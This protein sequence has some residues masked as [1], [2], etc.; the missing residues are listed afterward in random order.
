MR[1]MNCGLPISPARTLTNCP[2]CGAP[3]NSVQGVQQQQFEQGGWGN[4]NT[5]GGGAPQNNPWVQVGSTTPQR[6][7]FQQ[8]IQN[9]VGIA[10]GRTSGAG[11]NGSARPGF[12]ESPLTPR[13]SPYTPPTKQK[14]SRNL[15][16]VAGLCVIVGAILLVL[17]VVLGS[18][19]SAHSP[20]T[21][22]TGQT[23][24]T[25]VS[26]TQAVV[27]PTT[28][29][30]DASPTAS[31]SPSPTGTAYPDAQYISDA[32]MTTGVDSKTMQAQP[33]TTTFTVGS[34]MYVIFKLHP[35]SQGGAVCSLWYLNGNATPIT[36]YSFNVKGTSTQ[37]YTY[38]T[39][40]SPGA[41]YVELYWASDKSCSDKVL[42][43]HVDFTVTAS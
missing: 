22:N 15:F 7:S 23:N 34:N 5:G 4:P 30:A 31:A 8:G 29:T 35:P 11:F 14:N 1:C 9:Q 27:T 16:M 33:A 12:Q 3:L 24:A 13:H 32:Q 18:N 28:S 20:N 25:S 19:S 6:P 10:E 36:S 21:A 40:G 41:A 42:A 2:R 17:I 39:Y 38:A 26:T 43:Q 37:S